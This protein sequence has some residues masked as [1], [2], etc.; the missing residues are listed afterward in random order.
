MADGERSKDN[1]VAE[2][3]EKSR[4]SKAVLAAVALF[5]LPL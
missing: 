2:R 1:L 5:G 3:G 4:K